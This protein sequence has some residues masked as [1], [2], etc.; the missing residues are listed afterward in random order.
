MNI[1]DK[2]IKDANDDVYDE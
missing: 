1:V 2:E